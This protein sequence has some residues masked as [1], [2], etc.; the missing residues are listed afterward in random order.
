[1]KK[2]FAAAA[3]ATVMILPASNANAGTDP[4]LGEIMWVGY[5][6]CPKGWMEANGQLLPIS[7]YSAM[8]SLFGTI[9]GGDGRTTFALPDLRGRAPMHAGTGPGLTPRTQGQRFGTE[10]VTLTAAEMPSHGHGL[11]AVSVQL[12]AS[13]QAASVSSP[14]NALLPSGAR[15]STL[16]A[17]AGTSSP[18][19]MAAGSVSLSGDTNLAGG[20]QSHANM[21]PVQVMT[22]CVAM[23]GVFPPR[24]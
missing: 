19:S 12:N 11:S 14:S 1:M 4:F 21:P 9:Y 5:N 16:Y 7:Q 3:L 8:F 2:L 10:T 22:A 18:V 15:G 24:P 6:F 23:V 20:S 17:P 13:D